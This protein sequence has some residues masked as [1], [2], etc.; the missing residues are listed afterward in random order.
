MSFK[1]CVFI[2]RNQCL[3]TENLCDVCLLYSNYTLI[4]KKLGGKKPTKKYYCSKE[5]AECILIEDLKLLEIKKSTGK[6]IYKILKCRYFA[7]NCLV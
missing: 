6:K 2:Y 4:C 7:D 5:C 3:D 1:I